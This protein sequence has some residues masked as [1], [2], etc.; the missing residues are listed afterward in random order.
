MLK[1][2]NRL[3]RRNLNRFDRSWSLRGP[4]CTKVLGFDIHTSVIGIFDT[5]NIVSEL[6]IDQYTLG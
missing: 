4:C 5:V 1:C 6:G 2:I 3:V